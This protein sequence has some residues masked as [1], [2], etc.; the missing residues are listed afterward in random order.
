MAYE[1]YCAACT[2]LGERADYNGKYYCSK[3]GD[4]YASDP[5]CYSF[6]EAYSRSNSARTNMYDNSAN[7]QSS[8]CYLTTIMCEILG[9]EDDNYYLNT[10]RNF[11]D[12]TMKINPN[13]FPLLY[14]YDLVGPIIA[15]NLN[16]DPNKL[17][18]AKTFFEKYIT[19]S[20][21]AIEENNENVAINIYKSMTY[22]LAEKYNINIDLLSPIQVPEYINVSTLGHGRTRKL[23]NEN[24]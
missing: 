15:K 8:S 4:V 6:V 24:A 18:I 3:K 17:E 10:L 11:R 13:Y 16:N 20:V 1:D 14:L 2:Y 22:A 19:K 5:K 9:Y 23:I 21:E 12:N 7:H